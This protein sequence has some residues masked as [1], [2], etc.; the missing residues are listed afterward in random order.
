MT[1]RQ[2]ESLGAEGIAVLRDKRKQQ[3]QKKAK[4]KTAD[5]KTAREKITRQKH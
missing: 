2:E 3:T 5:E 1:S 4:E